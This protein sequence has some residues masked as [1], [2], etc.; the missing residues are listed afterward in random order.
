M[1]ITYVEHFVRVKGK[2]ITYMEGWMEAKDLLRSYGSKPESIIKTRRK[3]VKP[4][5]K[6]KQKEEDH[7]EY[8]N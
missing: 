8:W 7:R 6:Q 2:D 5:E 1:I 4:T 3:L